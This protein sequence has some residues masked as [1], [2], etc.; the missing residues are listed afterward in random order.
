M[1]FANTEFAAYARFRK[2][3]IPIVVLQRAGIYNL[4]QVVNGRFLGDQD[5]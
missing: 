3:V 4:I 5:L 2:D 1:D